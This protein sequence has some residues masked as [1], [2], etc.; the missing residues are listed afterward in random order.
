[1]TV[2]MTIT[3]SM[4]MTLSLVYTVLCRYL[5]LIVCPLNTAGNSEG[6]SNPLQG[7]HGNLNTATEERNKDKWWS[8]CDNFVALFC[9][10]ADEMFIQSDSQA[11]DLS[12]WYEPLSTNR[13]NV[14]IKQI[15]V[16]AN[17]RE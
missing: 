16:W 5:C 3:M 2:K 11:Q 15:K 12:K 7:R 8:I 10:L 17:L 9:P 1:M 4:K 14:I 13:A 6:S